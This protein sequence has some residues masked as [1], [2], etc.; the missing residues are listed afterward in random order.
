MLSN[1]G[2]TRGRKSEQQRLLSCRRYLHFACMCSK[3]GVEIGY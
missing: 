3:P 2:A 1:M